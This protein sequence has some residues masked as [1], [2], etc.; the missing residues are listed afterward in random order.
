MVSGLSPY[1]NWMTLKR[2]NPDSGD[3]MP[4]AKRIRVQNALMEDLRVEDMGSK[5]YLHTWCNNRSGSERISQRLDWGLVNARWATDYPQI[6]CTNELALGSDHS[7]LVIHMTE[8]KKRTTRRFKF[9]EMWLEDPLCKDII[10]ESWEGASMDTRTHGVHLKLK[11]CRRSLTL[12]SKAHFGNNA[13]KIIDLKNQLGRRNGPINTLAEVQ[14]ERK[15]KAHLKETWKR[16]ELY[17]RQRSRV[18]WFEHGDRNT[19][20]FPS[21]NIIKEEEK[22]NHPT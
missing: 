9:E 18:K 6:Q 13:R 21:H 22:P 4:K 10:R 8:P 7:P 19:T 14:E 20:F 15:L 12:W 16:E 5:G 3:E 11:A 1:M 17:W 2:M